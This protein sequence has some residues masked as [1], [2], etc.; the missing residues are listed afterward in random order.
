MLANALTSGQH[1]AEAAEIVHELATNTSDANARRDYENQAAELTRVA[2]VNRQ[3]EAFNKIVAQVNAGK[4]R[5]AIK[6]L[7]EFLPTATDPNIV[8]DAKK[9]QKQLAAWRP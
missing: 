8:R 3:V 4:Y 2:D 9:L 5:E 1:L 6:A 7:N